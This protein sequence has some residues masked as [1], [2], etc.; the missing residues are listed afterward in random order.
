MA[1]DDGIRPEAGW[2]PELD[3]LRLR[4]K[5]ALTGLFA[6]ALAALYLLASMEL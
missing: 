2:Q 4:E 6:A 5:L 1:N 3:E